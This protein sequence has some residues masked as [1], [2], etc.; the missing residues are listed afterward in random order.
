LKKS[1][2]IYLPFWKAEFSLAKNFFLG[3]CKAVN[4]A[5]YF[6][7]FFRKLDQEYSF[8]HLQIE[9]Q[10]KRFTNRISNLLVRRGRGRKEG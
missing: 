5:K 9:P 3:P 8:R 2:I 4:K 6:K 10:I 7:K 1:F